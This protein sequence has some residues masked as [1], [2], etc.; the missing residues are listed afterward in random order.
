[1]KPNFYHL[2]TGEPDEREVLFRQ[3]EGIRK[4]PNIHFLPFGLKFLKETRGCFY[5]SCITL[6]W[7]Y[8]SYFVPAL[9]LIPMQREQQIGSWAL[10]IFLFLSAATF[11]SL[12]RSCLSD[13]GYMPFDNR[14][15][16]PEQLN[17]SHCK[18]CLIQRPLKSHHCSRCQRCVRRMDHH[19]PWINSCVGEDNQWVFVLLLLYGFLLSGCALLIDVLHFYYFKPCTSCDPTIFIFRNQRSLMYG[20]FATGMLLELF[21]FTQLFTQIFNI[22]RDKT[23]LE[24]L[25]NVQKPVH[26]RPAITKTPMDSF[27]DVF[28]RGPVLLWLNPFRRRRGRNIVVYADVA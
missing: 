1:M 26:E 16:A 5:L 2:A 25:I 11:V 23:T 22:Y 7:A 9:V 28:G 8:N 12:V 18:K 15:T 13:P 17:W 3:A 14:A 4:S 21:C 27:C 20:C 24:S 19:C 6:M 10:W